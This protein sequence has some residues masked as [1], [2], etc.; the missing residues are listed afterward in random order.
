MDFFMFT[1]RQDL[2]VRVAFWNLV[3]VDFV[4]FQ[5]PEFLVRLVRKC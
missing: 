2:E 5:F 3:R 4:E 1:S